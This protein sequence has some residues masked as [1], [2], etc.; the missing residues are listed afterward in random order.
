MKSIKALPLLLLCCA[1]ANLAGTATA[2]AW[3]QK[4]HDVTCCIAERHLTKK[5]ANK[6]DKVL[7]GKSIIYWGNWLDNASHTP[8]YSYTKTW[9]Y[10][11]IDPDEDYDTMEPCETGDVVTA[12]NAQIAAL[13]SGTLNKEAEAL[14]LKMLVHLVGD[15]HCP[16][17]VGRK[18]DLGGNLW[19]VQFFNKGKNLHSI[20]DTGVIEEAHNWT[21]SEWADQI[22]IAG[23]ATIKNIVAGTPDDWCRETH[24]I[25]ETIYENTPV[26][27]KLDYDYVE[28]NTPIVEQQLLRGGLRLATI[29]NEIYN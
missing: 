20:W 10:K 11:D 8:A 25:A 24:A 23:R 9:H 19:Q 4:G 7:D 16:M 21:Y 15:I 26:G 17:H 2:F 13:K 1:A 5:A 27:S 14:A 6:I 28:E 18:S 22:D 29:L 3:G 12:I